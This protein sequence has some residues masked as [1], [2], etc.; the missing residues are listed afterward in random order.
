MSGY[1]S[2][3]PDP[4]WWRRAADALRLFRRDDEPDLNYKGEERDD[5]IA[6]EPL[7]VTA[8]GKAA[9]DALRSL[10][11]NRARPPQRV[12]SE[13]ALA[14]A[15]AAD[16]APEE[17]TPVH[18]YQNLTRVLG[19]TLGR[20]L[21]ESG[22]AT[23]EG[24]ATLG[25]GVDEIPGTE[26][27]PL[28]GLGRASRHPEMQPERLAAERAGIRE[29]YGDPQSTGE[30]I[31][32]GA[33]RVAG[34]LAQFA[35]PS[36]WASRAGALPKIAEGGLRGFAGRSALNTAVTAPVTAAQA[37]GSPENSATGT[38]AEAFDSEPLRRLASTPAGRVAGDLG[39]DL[40]ASGAVEGVT[41]AVRAAREIP[42]ATRGL[43]NAGSFPAADA[44]RRLRD[45]ATYGADV[46]RAAPG[47]TS[48]PRSRDLSRPVPTPESIETPAT[49]SMG[50]EGRALR[51]DDPLAGTR[52]V[53]EAGNP[54]TV[55]HGT[56]ATFTDF[57]PARQQSDALFGPGYYFTE[58]PEIAGGDGRKVAGYSRKLQDGLRT[59]SNSDEAVEQTATAL[60]DLKARQERQVGEYRAKADIASLPD[61][62]RDYWS[63]EADSVQSDIGRTEE[64][65]R[66]LEVIRNAPVAAP[67]VRPARL[68]VR[69]PFDADATYGA[70]ETARILRAVGVDR[71]TDLVER[72]TDG[73]NGHDL[74]ALLARKDKRAANETLRA[75]GY[76]GITHTGG[77]ITGNDPHRVWI[78]FDREQIRSPWG[79]SRLADQ[80][81]T[82]DPAVVRTLATG[83]A[84]AVAGSGIDAATG[85]D[86][87][88]LEGAL[89]GLA[90][91]VGAGTALSRYGGGAPVQLTGDALAAQAR[92]ES[93]IDWT[94]A[95]QRQSDS[96]ARGSG[97]AR[98]NRL[99][100]ALGN[101][102]GP[103][104]R[105]GEASGLPATQNPLDR[106]TLWR[107][108]EATIDRALSGDGIPNP[109]DPRELLGAPLKHVVEPLGTS[110]D[111]IRQGFTYAVNK[112][113][114]G[115]GLQGFGGDAA[116]MADAQTLVSALEQSPQIRLFEERLR[117][118]TASLGDFAVRSGLFTP[119]Q[120]SRIEASD[121]LYVPTR[122]IF[123]KSATSATALKT[124]GQG[125]VNVT[126]PVKK[127]T[128]SS[129]AVYDPA[130]ALVEYTEAIIRRSTAARVGSALIDAL[131]A[132][133]GGDALLSPVNRSISPKSA[134]KALSA[135]SARAAGASLDPDVVEMLD[136]LA[137]Y[138]VDKENPIIWRNG[139]NGREEFQLNAPDLMHAVSGLRE[140][141]GGAL[142]QVLDMVLLP[143][144]RVFTSATTALSPAFTLLTN[145]TRD[146][147]DTLAKSQS[148]VRPDDIA[149]GYAEGIGGAVGM[150]RF[151]EE[152]RQMGLGQVSV[153]HDVPTATT[154]TRKRAVVPTTQLDR[155]RSAA[156]T[157]FY[158]GTGI[159]ILEGL[160]NA[161][162]V[163]PRLGEAHATMRRLQPE[164]E[165]GQITEVDALLRSATR[166]RQLI[167][168]TNEPG[169][170]ILAELKRYLPFMGAAL[171]GSTT[172]IKGW[173]RNPARMASVLGGM[174][175]VP[176]VVAWALKHRSPEVL[177]QEN[178]RMPQE[179]A[180]YLHFPLTDKAGGPV[181]R[182]PLPQ[183][184][185]IVSAGI[186]SGLDGLADNEPQAA[187]QLW[188]SVQRAL[189]PWLGEV[190]SAPFRG[191]GL[192]NM[193]P[194]IP[195]VQ[196]AAEI[197]ANERTYDSRSIVPESMEGLLPED[198]RRENTPATADLLAAGARAVGFDEA[199]P[200][201]AEHAMR[202]VLSR[203]SD[204]ATQITDPLA[205]EI[206][207]R[208]APP[209]KIPPAVNRSPLLP[210]PLANPSPSTT[211]EE[212]R[213]YSLRERIMQVEESLK[214]ADES[215]DEDRAFQIMQDNG[216]L[217][218][219]DVL[220]IVEETDE[221]IKALREEKDAI[222]QMHQEGAINDSDA[223]KSL[224]DISRQ[225]ASIFRES[226]RLIEALLRPV[227]AA[228]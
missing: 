33:A 128:G 141:D 74:Y 62:D 197:M 60:R 43:E 166:G 69:N 13:R 217:A 19:R 109:D 151:A 68:A 49:R 184:F 214:Q 121:A 137:P 155:L 201:Q 81:G 27:T 175:A 15:L 182:M 12:E 20:G 220:G 99:M 164:V 65:M 86:R 179:R 21:A 90:V 224:D 131:Q 9:A 194:P 144:R 168:F 103:V 25:R 218:D 181:L 204:I 122:R 126:S 22:Q 188:A 78:A 77:G 163:G 107:Q 54:R 44:L 2:Y 111:A 5:A 117:E 30:A 207:G 140:M 87:S 187:D 215:E 153:F 3:E 16:T 159:T 113:L 106:T 170:P 180:A 226:K 172:H 8:P 41:G 83:G 191:G 150:S 26:F 133:P 210:S 193:V 173:Q 108:R 95:L 96:A 212:Q 156:R 32:Y 82:A 80:Y 38:L 221:E 18:P 101:R 136:D 35:A 228:R 165:S 29:E 72:G 223:R 176:T 73:M 118:Y 134:A 169:N 198:R 225:E 147:V 149:R 171:Q 93:R 190:A 199:S 129:R 42:G 71:Q 84:G 206:M 100:D 192:V 208:E 6:L 120:W 24:L 154:G 142:R 7:V 112:R 53:D 209:P 115:R 17:T 185:G 202:G 200:L 23:L 211:D 98:F 183:E 178:S 177:E 105:V 152:M 219:E 63:R 36:T 11:A 116:Q 213:Y 37:A 92:A 174:V 161:T 203:Y 125:L 97:T 56:T 70:E 162:E 189:P 143:I 67:N 85:D 104:E 39:M 132:I 91:G 58:T 148:G 55:Y 1:T 31:G 205:R 114:L 130:T 76:D 196:Q 50:E 47:T 75:L 160:G 124:G 127:F 139:P 4:P 45:P 94:G 123:G 28:A 88:P 102:M 57:D 51:P 146:V 119:E 135:R 222:I 66:Q 79:D 195:G 158:R 138:A 10:P 145:P 186:R 59:E 64:M 157:G 61:H 46:G 89:A 34:D 216:P 48:I 40:L 110:P 52:V 227:G 14:A 167:D